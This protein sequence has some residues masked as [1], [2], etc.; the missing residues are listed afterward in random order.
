MEDSMKTVCEMEDKEYRDYLYRK[1]KKVRTKKNLDMFLREAVKDMNNA[2]LNRHNRKKVYTV[3]ACM[4][5]AAYYASNSDKSDPEDRLKGFDA[6]FAGL[7]DIN[8]RLFFLCDDYMTK[9]VSYGHLLYPGNDF[10]FRNNNIIPRDTWEYIQDKAQELLLKCPDAGPELRRHWYS[11]VGGRVPYD[12]WEV[13]GDDRVEKKLR[14]LDIIKK[15]KVNMVWLWGA[16]NLDASNEKKC[17]NY[18]WQGRY[19]PFNWERSLTLEE[20]NLLEEVMCS[21]KWI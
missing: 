3:S 14:A 8:D 12:N 11:I 17:E 6:S 19:L 15:K 7:T 5:A 9:I 20:F 4:L 10:T 16:C 21:E 13:E 18:N 2:E 1:A